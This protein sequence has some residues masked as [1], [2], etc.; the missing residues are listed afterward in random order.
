MY[1]WNVVVVMLFVCVLLLSSSSAAYTVRNY[2]ASTATCVIFFLLIFVMIVVLCVL[3]CLINCFM[4]C[5]LVFN[6]CVFCMYGI[7]A[8]RVSGS[9][10]VV[11]Y[12]FY[13]MLCVV[14]FLYVILSFF[15][16]CRYYSKCFDLLF[17]MCVKFMKN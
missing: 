14:M 11:S 12:F 2:V 10:R 9:S 3:L 15:S 6:L 7:I 1:V 5:G 8:S 13:S 4:R 16:C 17:V